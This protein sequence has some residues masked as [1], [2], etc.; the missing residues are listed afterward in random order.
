MSR[1]PFPN[2]WCVVVLFAVFGSVVVATA[3]PAE[4][5]SI[6]AE[7][8]APDVERCSSPFFCFEEEDLSDIDHEEFGDWISLMPGYYPLDQGGYGQPLRGLYMN[9]PMYSIELY[10]RGRRVEDPLLGAP[11]FGLIPPEALSDVTLDLFPVWSPGV[12]VNADL[13]TMAPVPP[14]SRIVTR[15][16]FYGLGL[17]DFDLSEKISPTIILNGG[18][19]I[20]TYGGRVANSEAYGL[21]LRAEVV[22]QDTTLESGQLWGWWGV[23]QNHLSSQVPF[24]S[25]DYNR[26]R[27]ETDAVLHWRNFTFHGYGIHQRET[28]ASGD[29]DTWQELGL[30]VGT[31]FGGSKLGADIRA[32]AAFADWRLSTQ[33]WSRTAFGDARMIAHWSAFNGFKM[34]SVAGID[35]SDDFD[36]ANHL[37]ISAEVTAVNWL[38]IFGGASHHQRMPSR[39]E[40]YAGFEPGLHYLPYDPVLFQNPDLPLEG[41]YDLK[42]EA[43]FNTIIGARTAPGFISGTLAYCRYRIQDPVTWH[44]V[45]GTVKSYNAGEEDA[46]GAVGWFT[47]QPWR[48]LEVG[49]TGSFLPRNDG[50]NRLFPEAIGHAWIQYRRMLFKDNLDL[51]IQV[52]EDYWGQRSFPVAGGWVKREED[53][54]LS[55]RIGIRIYGFHIYWGVNNI[56][57]RHYELFPGLP[58]MHKEE[59]WG[60]SWNF[61]N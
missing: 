18:G 22:W 6:D 36:P 24:E 14:T 30:I 25:I 40:A 7:Y 12:R 49:G 4:K 13:R 28:Y 8:D 1:F 46:D 39:F 5:D 59:V 11:E 23:A 35:L 31:Q 32:R 26:K 57:D 41:N 55:A 34:E 42:N 56:L 20:S 45:S 10:Y 37:G 33:D 44:V 58:M 61:I 43:Y 19:R 17:V 3:N 9:L 15:D 16:G 29:A 52:W 50:E 38:S 48:D 47:L 21:N 60:F 2:P 53:F 27:Y 54:T 51:R